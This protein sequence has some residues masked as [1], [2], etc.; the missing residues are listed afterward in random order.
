MKWK[1]VI[2]YKWLTAATTVIWERKK[3]E[4]YIQTTR[5]AGEE[6]LLLHETSGYFAECFPV[7]SLSI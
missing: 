4:T 5:N 6:E 2:F 1:E 7:A 3:N